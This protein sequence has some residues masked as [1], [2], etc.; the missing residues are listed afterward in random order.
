MRIDRALHGSSLAPKHRKKI[1]KAPINSHKITTEDFLR[2]FKKTSQFFLIIHLFCRNVKGK[3]NISWNLFGKR[4]SN[5]FQNCIKSYELSTGAFLNAPD[6]FA[7]DQK[8]GND[9]IA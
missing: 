6:R 4:E 5:V 7:V 2:F 9:A 3:Y 8:N 1:T